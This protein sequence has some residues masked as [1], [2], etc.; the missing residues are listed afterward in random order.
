[1]TNPA[2]ATHT[3]LS[4]DGTTIHYLTIG[5]GPSVIVVPGALE[6]AEEFSAFAHTLAQ[7]FTIHT[8][9]RRGRG[10][11]GPQ[12]DDYSIAKECE[13]IVALQQKTGAKYIVGH[14]YGGLVALEAART[15]NVF[16]KIAV[17]EPGVSIDGSIPTSWMPMYEQKLAQKKHFDAFIE[18]SVAA[19]PDKGKKIPRFIMKVILRFVLKPRELRQILALLPESLREHQEVARLDNTHHTYQGI[20]AS[21]LLMYSGQSN[22]R[23]LTWVEPMTKQL[24]EILL[25]SELKEFPKLDHFGIS[26]KGSAE[27]A[28]TVSEF[29]SK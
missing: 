27:V 13:D 25:H 28:T 29:F 19:G 5:A 23:G 2:N 24:A 10:L 12:G 14:S 6:I 9:E 22:K 20:T 1:M 18:F 26:K 11:S 7:H 16:T 21:A 8:I 15:T 17:Y 4:K 3:V